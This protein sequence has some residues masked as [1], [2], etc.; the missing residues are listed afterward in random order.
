MRISRK[1]SRT[2]EPE[3]SLLNLIDVIFVLLIFFMVITTFN[4][5]NQFGLAL[6]EAAVNEKVNKEQDIEVILNKDKEYFLKIDN[7]VKKINA[8]NLSAELSHLGNEAKKNIR[9]TADKNLEYGVIIDLMAA[10][11]NSGIKNINLNMQSEA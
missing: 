11:K 6:P 5:Y 2:Q 1:R 10:L 4:T 9:V 8:E 7:N 3:I